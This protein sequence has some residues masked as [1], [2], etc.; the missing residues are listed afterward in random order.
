MYWPD[1]ELDG[2]ETVVSNQMVKPR[3][4]RLT[5]AAADGDLDRHVVCG[6][7]PAGAARGC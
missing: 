2:C 1:V 5:L 7:L 4:T 6:Q 3:G